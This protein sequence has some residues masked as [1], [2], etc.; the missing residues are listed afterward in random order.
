MD[1]LFLPSAKLSGEIT[2][3]GNKFWGTWMQEIAGE[4][5]IIRFDPADLWGGIHVYSAENAYLGFA[6]CLAKVGFYDMDE[7]R[8]HSRARAAWIKAEKAALAAHRRYTAAGLGA[9]LDASAPETPTPTVEAK[10]VRGAFGKQAAPRQ[11]AGATPMPVA[12]LEQAQAALVI[13]LQA[14]RARKADDDEP[15]QRFRRA[16]ELER[17]VSTGQ[18][19]TRDQDRWLSIYSQGAEYRSLASLYADFG[20][21]LFG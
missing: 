4:R 20:E 14:A 10:V 3:Q 19:I 13:E 16:L 2:F 21:T 12:D 18:P 8:L 9:L 1:A 7:A 15:K 6:P 5:I 11:I 17:A